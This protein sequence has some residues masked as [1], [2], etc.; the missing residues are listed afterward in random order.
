[1]ID[2]GWLLKEFVRVVNLL[3]GIIMLNTTNDFPYSYLQDSGYHLHNVTELAFGV[4]AINDAHVAL[5]RHLN[6]WTSE[7][8]EV[9]I[10]RS[11]IDASQ[12]RQVVALSEEI[13]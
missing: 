10:G 9:V 13:R 8:Y 12:L 7:S 11:S 1:M 4:R 2:L 6:V 5:S 3:T